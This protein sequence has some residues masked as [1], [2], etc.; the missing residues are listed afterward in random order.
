MCNIDSQSRCPTTSKFNGFH[1]PLS[2]V[3]PPTLCGTQDPNPTLSLESDSIFIPDGLLGKSPTLTNAVAGFFLGVAPQP[4]QLLLSNAGHV[5]PFLVR[6]PKTNT[7]HGAVN[8]MNHSA[9]D[10][11]EED[12]DCPTHDHIHNHLEHFFNSLSLPWKAPTEMPMHVGLSCVHNDQTTVIDIFS[13]ISGDL[14]QHSFAP[15]ACFDRAKC[16]CND[17]EKTS[18]VTN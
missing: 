14:P 18:E 8:L 9:M 13:F 15:F 1:K 12:I 2:I 5:A 6:P 10:L 11:S 4:G 7:N 17:A 16:P 3:L